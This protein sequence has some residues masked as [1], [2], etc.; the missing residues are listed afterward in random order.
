MLP[1]FSQHL[2][3]RSESILV[4]IGVDLRQRE[5]EQRCEGRRR[6]PDP[7]MDGYCGPEELDGMLHFAI[8]DLTE[9]VPVICMG[10]EHLIVQF[11]CDLAALGEMALCVVSVALDETDPCGRPQGFA[12][13]GAVFC[14]QQEH[15]IE[16]TS[17]VAEVP[18]GYPVVPEQRSEPHSCE[19]L[20]RC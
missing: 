11:L 6:I 8:E 5:H 2:P 10:C 9:R 15:T 16:P 17:A 1:A 4:P 13:L 7:A 19:F 18:A 14:R 20:S 12:P 3:A